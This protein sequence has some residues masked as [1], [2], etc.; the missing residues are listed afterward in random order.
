MPSTQLYQELVSL[1]EATAAAYHLIVE[2]KRPRLAADHL[3]RLRAQLALA[4]AALAP[5]YVDDGG[6][7]RQIAMAELESHL[8]QR[9]PSSR[10]DLAAFYIRRLDLL[11]AV[12]LILKA[13]QDCDVS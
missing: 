1:K 2:E 7:K 3:E 9:E 13:E 4:L 12:E 11:R 8:F 6:E 10:A 5:V